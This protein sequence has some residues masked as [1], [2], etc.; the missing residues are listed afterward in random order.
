ML[1]KYVIAVVCVAPV[2]V[3][4]TDVPHGKRIASLHRSF[5]G[6]DGVVASCETLIVFIIP[7][8]VTVMVALRADVAVF[9]VAVMVNVLLLLPLVREV[10]SHEAL[11]DTVH[12]VLEVTVIAEEAPPLAAKL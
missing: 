8:P 12:D 2:K 1:L 5:A 9:A 4:C 11:L 7:P 6:A 3:P 10:V